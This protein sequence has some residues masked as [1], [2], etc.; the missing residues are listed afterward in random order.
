MPVIQARYFERAVAAKP[1]AQHYYTVDE[2]LCLCIYVI[3]FM[4]T[5]PLYVEIH[6]A[7]KNLS[8]LSK[9]MAFGLVL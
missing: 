7:N 5:Y 1:R 2:M 8:L 6:Y 4:E 3:F 9:N